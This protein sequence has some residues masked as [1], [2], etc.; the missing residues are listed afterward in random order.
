MERFVGDQHLACAAAFDRR[1][2][3]DKTGSGALTRVDSNGYR[4]TAVPQ[5]LWVRR[6][7]PATAYS[8]W[9]L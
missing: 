6:V 9:T 8:G 1:H 4:T 7:L 2:A 3:L 5:T